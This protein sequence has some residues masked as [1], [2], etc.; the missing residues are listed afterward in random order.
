MDMKRT[1]R[2]ADKIIASI[3][4]MQVSD[5][6][7][8][9]VAMYLVIKTNGMLELRSRLLELC[10]QIKWEHDREVSRNGQLV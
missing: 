8:M 2:I 9:Y 3:A 7:M 5:G 10:T 4:D 1:E 6:E